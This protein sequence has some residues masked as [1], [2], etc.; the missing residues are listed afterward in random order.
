[1]SDD[2]TTPLP[3]ELAQQI[4]GYL[5]DDE[6]ARVCKDIPDE[7]C[8]EQPVAFTLQLIAQTLT[9]VG[10]AL[11]S[12]RLVLAWMLGAL[13]APAIFIALLVPLRESLALLPQL[14]IAQAIRER[15]IRK[16]FWVLGSFGQAAALA[17]MVPVVWMLEGFAA[18]LAITGLLVVFSLS[19]GVC[20][21]AA[22]DV[23]G[24][25]VSKSRRGR[26]NGSAASAAGFITLAVALV[27]IVG[28]GLEQTS[29]A[30]PAERTLFVA[31]LAISTLLWIGAAIVFARVPEVPGATEGGGN[32]FT[33][34]IRSLSLLRDDKDFRDFV[35]ARALLV[36]TAFAIPYIVVLIQRGGDGGL[37]GLGAL[38]LADGAAGL[39][40]SPIWGRWSDAASHRVMAGAA[41]LSVIVMGS[42]LA[43]HYAVVEVLTLAP[44]SAL[45]LFAAAVAHHG[46]RVARKTYL[47][48]L[49]NSDN[50]AQY[51]AV[52][53]TVIGIFLLAGAGLG[54]LD[55]WLGTT[56]VLWF[57]MIV[58]A[59]ASLR[60]LALKSVA[61]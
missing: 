33:E 45:V 61:D 52:S 59:L 38:L 1:M 28:A 54:V 43:L 37:A 14:F 22:K 5:A 23:L 32:A 29:A 26:L 53:N 36:S 49:A 16:T 19:R 9:K 57:L 27:I 35:I 50:R 40:S 58:G 15:A 25:T 44:V 10:D 8:H 13:G 55:A 56:S 42:V 20:S 21:V 2:N 48:D 17:A 46:A 11:V 4:Y 39:L 7:A 3:R 51:T 31:I 18:G 24:K 34:A 6:D 47:V 41:A 30:F 12:A 60:S